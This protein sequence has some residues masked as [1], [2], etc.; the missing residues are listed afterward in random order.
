M[1]AQ[2]FMRRTLRAGWQQTQQLQQA[3][4]A[5]RAAQAA[6][7]LPPAQAPAQAA[8]LGAAQRADSG[9]AALLPVL[10]AA[11]WHLPRLR[12]GL[13]AVQVRLSYPT[14]TLSSGGGVPRCVT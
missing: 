4:Q 3:Q 11:L 2:L 9:A 6:Q 1:L 14:L 7:R 13:L 12:D 5:Q 10:A 8:R